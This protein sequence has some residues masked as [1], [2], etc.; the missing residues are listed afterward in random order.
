MDKYGACSIK[1]YKNSGSRAYLDDL[2]E[3]M[4]KT[5]KS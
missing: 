1:G 2:R 5:V 4:A 3:F